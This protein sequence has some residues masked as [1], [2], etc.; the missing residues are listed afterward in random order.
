VLST[1]KS[2]K[3]HVPLATGFNF[4]V[5]QFLPAKHFS[6]PHLERGQ[7]PSFS[8]FL[9]PFLTP[10]TSSICNLPHR[11][12]Q[13][14]SSCAPRLTGLS[15]RAFFQPLISCV[16][17]VDSNALFTLVSHRVK[18]MQVVFCFF[19]CNQKYLAQRAARVSYFQATA[20]PPS[21][22]SMSVITIKLLSTHVFCAGPPKTANRPPYGKAYSTPALSSVTF[23]LST[24]F[25]T[26]ARKLE[27]I[28]CGLY[29]TNRNEATPNCRFLERLYR[30][31]WFPDS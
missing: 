27:D 24:W 21:C 23:S 28:T 7:F 2:A 31:E 26:A 29:W 1:S 19:L 25:P 22:S 10:I 12:V 14:Q 20:P 9:P 5:S 8:L 15:V 17:G 4:I 11:H 13:K 18:I 6:S 16:G 30:P 3:H